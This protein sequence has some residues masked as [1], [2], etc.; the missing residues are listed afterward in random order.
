MKKNTKH[1][2]FQYHGNKLTKEHELI[3]II[4]IEIF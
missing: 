3:L 4:E 2:V 1:L